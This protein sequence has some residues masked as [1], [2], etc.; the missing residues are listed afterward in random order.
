M[1]SSH[2]TR[3]SS[4]RRGCMNLAGGNIARNGKGDVKNGSASK[5]RNLSLRTSAVGTGPLCAALRTLKLPP[6]KQRL[7]ACVQYC[8]RSPYRLQL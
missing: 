7:F 5:C 6:T 4:T 2:S 3:S 8:V 1:P